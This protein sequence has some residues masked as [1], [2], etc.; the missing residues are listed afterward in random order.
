VAGY[1]SFIVVLLRIGVYDP[2]F[3]LE[4]V[5]IHPPSNVSPYEKPIYIVAI[6]ITQCPV[7]VSR[8]SVPF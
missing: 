2:Y 3:E 7:S 8:F 1:L 4:R 5:Y 6:A